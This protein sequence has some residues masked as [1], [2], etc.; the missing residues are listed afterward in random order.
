MAWR[1]RHI[2]MWTQNANNKTTLQ[3]S[4]LKNVCMHFAFVHVSSH[5]IWSSLTR[6]LYQTSKEKE[7]YLVRV[8][9][10]VPCQQLS[11]PRLLLYRQVRWSYLTSLLCQR[12]RDTTTFQ[13]DKIF[14]SNQNKKEKKHY[15]MCVCVRELS[16]CVQI[17]KRIGPDRFD[18]YHPS[19]NWLVF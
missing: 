10:R 9:E 14:F 17:D 12:Q 19:N 5:R 1:D 11:E 13:S 18:Y 8:C 6:L 4:L 16:S 3:L 15:F 7:L 2:T